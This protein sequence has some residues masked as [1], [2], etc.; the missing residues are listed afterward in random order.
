MRLAIVIPALDEA[1]GI[2]ATVHH[3]LEHADEVWVSDG[4][5]T[6]GTRERAAAAGARVLLGP[7]GRGPQID[8]GC[9]AATGDGLLVLHAD[10]RLPP[11]GG[12]AVRRAL[13]D[14]AAGGGFRV[15][16]DDPRRRFRLG[17][18][19]V[20]LR[21]RLTGCPLGDQAQFVR[22]EVYAAL[23]GYRHWP[24][25]EDLDF[26]RRLKRHGRTVLLSPPVTTAAR[27]YVRRGIAR[28][29]AINWLIWGLYFAGVP[30]ERLRRLY[31]DLR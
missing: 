27:R 22:R 7:S 26:A 2:A 8:L 20:D 30:P 9:R 24:L 12:E 5:S 11:G 25:L 4:G 6:D 28:T 10:T 3:A 18:R 19:L 1:A 31:G 17:S 16:F 23:G 13:A 14:G 29:I 21:T 15:R